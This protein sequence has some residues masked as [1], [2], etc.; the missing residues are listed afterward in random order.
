MKRRIPTLILIAALVSTGIYFAT[1]GHR[2]S[3]TLTGIVTTDEVIV[4][5]LVQGRLQDLKVNQGDAV[6]RGDLL[7]VI[8]PQ[9]WSTLR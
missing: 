3:I 4:S 8:Q 2:N 7:A 5:P 6:K 9:Q 1:T